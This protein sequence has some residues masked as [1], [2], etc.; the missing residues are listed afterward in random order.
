M[1]L[2]FGGTWVINSSIGKITKAKEACAELGQSILLVQE[3]IGENWRGDAG[4]AMQVSLNEIWTEINLAHQQLT[5]AEKEVRSQGDFIMNN[6]IDD[7]E[8]SG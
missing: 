3:K 7:D 8:S 1:G 2:G 5:S 6:W 4:T